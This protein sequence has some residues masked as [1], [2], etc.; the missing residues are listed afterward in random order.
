[1]DAVVL[2]ILLT[3][4]GVTWVRYENDETTDGGVT[5]ERIMVD[6]VHWEDFAHAPERHWADVERRG[7]VARR[8]LLTRAEGRKRFG[9][10]FSKVPMSTPSRTSETLSQNERDGSTDKYA[11][12]WEIWDMVSKKRIFV[13]KGAEDVLESSDPQYRLEKFLSLPTTRLRHVDQ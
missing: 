6:Y 12:V 10:E 7:W 8:T 13:S 11:E 4:R 1:M 5:N 9:P 3:A 2:D